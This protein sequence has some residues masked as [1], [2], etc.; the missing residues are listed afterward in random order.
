MRLEIFHPPYLFRGQRPTI[1]SA[2]PQCTYGA[3]D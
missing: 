1:T 3:D 2:P